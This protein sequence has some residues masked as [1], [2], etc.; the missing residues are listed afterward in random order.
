[1]KKP[2]T[3]IKEGNCKLDKPLIACPEV[4]PPA[5]LEPKP[6]RNPPKARIINPFKENNDSILNNSSGWIDFGADIP[7]FAKS[8]TVDSDILTAL[9][10]DK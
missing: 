9:P 4:Q 6:T 10:L 1:M 2:I 5:Y 8:L 7:S 3:V